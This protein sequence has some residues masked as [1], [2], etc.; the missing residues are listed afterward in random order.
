[1]DRHRCR[2]CFRRFSNGRALG[3]HMR[4]HVVNASTAAAAGHRRPKPPS[5]SGLSSSF[6]EATTYEF[7]RRR[8]FRAVDPEFSSSVAVAESGGA[9]SSYVG[10]SEADSS[11]FRRRLVRPRRTEGFSDEAE[12]LSSVSDGAREEDVALCLMLLSRDTW[13]KSKMERR[14]SLDDEEKEDVDDELTLL[15]AGKSCTKRTKYQCVTCR[16]FFK[17]YQALSGHRAN[18]KNEGTECTPTTTGVRIHGSGLRPTTTN[19]AKLYQCPY[20]SRTFIS[21]QALGGH[22]RSHLATA[23]TTS[24]APLSIKDDGF[25][26]LNQPALFEEETE[27]SALSVA[28]EIASK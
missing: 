14:Q 2:I 24:P 15:A 7:P 1:M 21:G 5:L 11:S 25:I 6:L 19:T 16:K 8:S 4:S 17:S 28:T 27:L 20:C 13:S 18:Q 12:R 3:G 23:T 26:D 10:E 9:G 22:K